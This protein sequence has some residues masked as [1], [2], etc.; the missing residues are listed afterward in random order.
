MA[1]NQKAEISN[2]QRPGKRLICF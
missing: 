1:L 2:R